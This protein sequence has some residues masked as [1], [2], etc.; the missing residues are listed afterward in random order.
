MPRVNPCGR[1][2]GKESC[3]PWGK[4]LVIS[5]LDSPRL[6][7]SPTGLMF[8]E[9]YE[10]AAKKPPTKS[11]IIMAGSQSLLSIYLL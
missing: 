9:R 5:F 10:R 2:K 6:V 8:L 4:N 1:V 3:E 7:T 11:K